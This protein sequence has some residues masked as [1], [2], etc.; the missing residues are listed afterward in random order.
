MGLRAGVCVAAAVVLL[1]SDLSSQQPT[2]KSTTNLIEVDAVVHDHHGE[3]VRGLTAADMTVLEDGKPQ[4]ISQFFLVTHDAPGANPDTDAAAPDSVQYNAHRI[5]VLLFD[6]GHLANESLFR[7]KAGAEWFVSQAIGDGDAAGIFLNGGMFHGRLTT[8][9]RELLAGVKTV[10]PA[11]DN[12]QGLLATFREW[13]RIPSEVDAMRVAEGDQQLLQSL[14]QQAC[15]DEPANC[16][17]ADFM[18]QIENQIQMK[19]RLYIR[20]ARVLTDQTM[21]NLEKVTINLTRLP[22]RKTVMFFSEGFF[23]EEVR[24]DLA[25]IAAEAARGGTTIYAIDGRGLINGLG[26]NPDVVSRERPRSTAFDTGEDGPVILADGTGGFVVRNIDDI[27]RAMGLV[28]RD[29]STYY[30]IGYE[31]TNSKIDN[32]VRKLE[33]RVDRPDVT[34]RAR[35]GY[36]PSTL[37]PQQSIWR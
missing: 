2:F 15:M 5:F 3:F 1:S 9:R 23:V 21:R 25:R 37:P 29:T 19:S 6:E 36:L 30:E 7:V 34:V 28:V 4:K 27:S 16:V 33:V 14:A 11:F 10:K 31:P 32:K 22:G 20:Q 8:D 13:P 18:G 24:S 12:R 26:L 35:K 17:G